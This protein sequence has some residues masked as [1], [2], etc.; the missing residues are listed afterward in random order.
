[1]GLETDYCLLKDALEGLGHHVTGLS[2]HER[3]FPV[4][5]INIFLEVFSS[6]QFSS[7]RW[8]WYIPNPEWFTNRV[9]ELSHFDLILCRTKETERIFQKL[10]QK[11]QYLGF[12]SPD[13]YRRDIEKD[14]QKIFHLGGGSY[15]KGTQNILNLWKD[16]PS[17]PDLTVV[18][19]LDLKFPPQLSNLTLF[20]HRLSETQLRFYQNQCGIHLCPSEVEGFGHYIMEAMSAGAVVLTTNAPPMN[21][22][23][24]EPVC[25]VPFSV[26]ASQKLATRYFVDPQHLYQLI[27]RVLHLP[28]EDLERI[29]AKNRQIYLKMKKKFHHNLELLLQNAKTFD[30]NEC[31]S[32]K[33]FKVKRR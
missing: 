25:L 1:V 9:E 19:H 3:K 23:I 8:N 26:S 14:Y 2:W 33:L 17:F 10:K 22:L 4:A 27:L 12:T 24:M 7:A 31:L 11:T 28:K 30:S 29:S 18:T 13:C 6:D 32:L 5:D 16:C 15:Q 20:N 21:E